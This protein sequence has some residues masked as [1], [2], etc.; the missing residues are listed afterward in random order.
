MRR[1]LC[2]W[3]L[4]I[5]DQL[6]EWLTQHRL[7]TRFVLVEPEPVVVGLEIAQVAESGGGEVGCCHGLL[8]SRMRARLWSLVADGR[9]NQVA[10]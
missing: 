4:Q 3:H 10:D 8:V 5:A 7:V 1:D 9:G 6:Q 2:Q